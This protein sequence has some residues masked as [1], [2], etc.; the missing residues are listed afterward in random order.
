MELSIL[1]VE[2][3]QMR[4]LNRQ[5]RRL[6]RA[7]DVLSFSQVDWNDKSVGGLKRNGSDFLLGDLV[8]SIETLK[9]R[10]KGAKAFHRALDHCV[11]HGILHLM[12]WDHDL[13]RDRKRMRQKEQQLLGLL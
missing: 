11:V 13:A 9:R 2:D 10:F 4:S 12:G 7:T 1:L 3:A 5:Y 8:I 6:D